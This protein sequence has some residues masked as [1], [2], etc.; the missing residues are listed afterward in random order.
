MVRREIEESDL[1]GRI[2]TGP[3]QE[4]VQRMDR[5][6]VALERATAIEVGPILRQ[7]DF[8][9]KNAKCELRDAYNKVRE[10]IRLR[11]QGIER[12]VSE[13][14]RSQVSDAL[15]RG[16]F[17]I[18]EDLV[19]RLEDGEPLSKPMPPPPVQQRFDAF[20]PSQAELLAKWLRA[21]PDGLRQLS[22][23]GT[24][25]P[26]ELSDNDRNSSS[27]FAALAAAWVSCATNRG[28]ELARS[29][30]DLLEALGFTEPELQGFT[31]PAPRAA[32]ALFR[33]RV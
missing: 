12:P 21:R 25:V 7:S 17:A 28:S 24:S 15:Q 5:Q 8:D 6:R 4:L 10:R 26:T 11:L 18:A 31:A 16:Q 30:T 32:E 19:E 2:E 27:D 14:D 13:R 33:V 22:Y 29:L 20:F 3:A 23:A 9:R 1:N